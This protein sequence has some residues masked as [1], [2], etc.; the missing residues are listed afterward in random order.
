MRSF[1]KS[2]R[3]KGFLGVFAVLLFGIIFAAATENGSSPAS[4]V[5]GTI[6]SPLQSLS[7]K[8]ADNVDDFSIYFRSAA[9]YAQ[10][11]EELESQLADSRSQMV[12]YEKT[13]QQLELYEEFLELKKENEDFKF[14]SASVI[15]KD[16]TDAFG[17]F[18]LNKGELDGV[19]VNNPVIYGKYLVGVVVKAAPTYCVVNTVLNPEVNVSAYEVRTRES[20]FVTTNPELSR[21]GQCSLSGLVRST[22]IAPG[23]IVCTSGVGG[24]YP[25]DLI[26][27]VV[28]EV[29]NDTTNVSSY[30][31]INT[32]VDFEQLRD[33]FV[34]TEFRGMGV[35][36]VD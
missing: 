13:K 9:S 28:E 18:T 8:I 14:A 30:A 7:A 34:I 17:T 15:G 3:F 6:F 20:S 4:S 2:A 35:G 5:L 10:R 1:F 32:Q 22:S 25:A 27:G 24:I 33:V 16:S 26:I 21:N 12:D 29:R 36:D 11:V 19:K 31:V 23:G